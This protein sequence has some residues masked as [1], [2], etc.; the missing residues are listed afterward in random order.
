MQ[1][2][3]RPALAR[4]RDWRHGD[5]WLLCRPDNRAC[6]LLTWERAPPAGML[7][8][9]MWRYP[10]GRCG[11]RVLL[12]RPS[13]ASWSGATRYSTC[14]PVAR[15]LPAP[16]SGAVQGSRSGGD[17]PALTAFLSGKR[18]TLRGGGDFFPGAGLRRPLRRWRGHVHH[19]GRARRPLRCRGTVLS[20]RHDHANLPLCGLY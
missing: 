7:D 3:C 12:G 8:L 16:I 6:Q 20:G 17:R 11:F 2:S 13:P 5:D 18:P 10:R 14:A 1:T 19:V 9:T 15:L 4:P